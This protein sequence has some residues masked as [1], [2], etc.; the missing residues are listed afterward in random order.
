MIDLNMQHG[1][2]FVSTNGRSPQRDNTVYLLLIHT[3]LCA[4]SV[5]YSVSL[6]VLI[7]SCCV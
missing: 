4:V 1:G 3:N 6:T 7:I 5:A 2:S